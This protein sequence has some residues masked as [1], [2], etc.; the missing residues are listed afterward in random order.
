MGLHKFASVLR[1]GQWIIPAIIV[2]AAVIIAV[3]GDDWRLA[4]RFDRVWLSHGETW[5]LVSG[6]FTHLGWSHLA[7]N[8]TG[9]VLVWFLVGERFDGAGWWIVIGAC[10]TVINI[11]FWVLDPELI[12]YVGLSG[13]LHGLLAAGIIA[14][15]RLPDGETLLLAALLIGKLLWEQFSGPLP[16][17]EATSGG[18]VVVNAHLYGAAGGFLGALLTRVRVISGSSI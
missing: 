11:C 15:L 5:R 3:G 14:K 16:G 2:A 10:V 13:L 8:L 7:L 1:G 18:P 9:L 4:L 6:H 12:W 17:S